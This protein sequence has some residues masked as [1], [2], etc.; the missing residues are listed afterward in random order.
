MKKEPD[1]AEIL[2][3]QNAR[4]THKA[5]VRK[6]REK[7]RADLKAAQ[8]GLARELASISKGGN[9]LFEMLVELNGKSF[10]SAKELREAASELIWEHRHQLPTGFLITDLT[11]TISQNKLFVRDEKTG[12]IVITIP[13]DVVIVQYSNTGSQHGQ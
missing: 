4:N 6:A 12:V 2:A 10:G 13:K 1:S 11:T 7:Y 8:E 5:A 9:V 3:E